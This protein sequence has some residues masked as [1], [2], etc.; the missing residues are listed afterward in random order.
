MALVYVHCPECQSID[1]EHSVILTLLVGAADTAR[2]P[3]RGYTLPPYLLGAPRHC[4]PL[5]TEYRCR[6]ANPCHH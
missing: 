5:F 3:D 6:V 4:P 1:E 2:I